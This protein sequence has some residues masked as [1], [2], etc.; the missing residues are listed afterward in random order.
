MTPPA[1][2]YANARQ[3]YATSAVS[4]ASPARLL[5][6]LYERLLRDLTTA[7]SALQ[8]RDLAVANDQ[9]QHAQQIVL[10]L[11]SSLDTAA[12]SGGPALE[13]LYTWLHTELV[14]A[15]VEKDA[16]RVLTCKQIVEPL[17]DAWQQAACS[18]ASA[19]GRAVS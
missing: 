7:A 2:S 16:A 6:M 10:E 14:T 3:R 4:T 5:V 12:W 15:N 18:A 11:R 19:G 9:L 17:H 1:T 8:D 13:A